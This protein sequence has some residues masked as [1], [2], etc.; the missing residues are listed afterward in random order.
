VQRQYRVLALAIA[1]SRVDRC[2]FWFVL[3]VLINARSGRP[4]LQL[5]YSCSGCKSR[6]PT[7]VQ[8]ISAHGVGWRETAKSRPTVLKV[9]RPPR[10]LRRWAQLACLK[11]VENIISRYLPLHPASDTLP[12][13]ES[14]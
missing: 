6:R 7:C 13:A 14:P 5:S 3:R 12:A 2:Y 4:H 8:I 11:M 1:A 10:T 9:Q